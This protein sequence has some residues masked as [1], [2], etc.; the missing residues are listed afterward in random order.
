[1]GDAYSC[2]FCGKR[3]EDAF[4]LVSGPACF[5]CD[6]CI[7]LCAEVLAERRAEEPPCGGGSNG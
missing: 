2:S 1:M 5:I 7:D 4:L 6:E 3:Q